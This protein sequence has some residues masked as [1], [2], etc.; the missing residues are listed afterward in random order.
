MDKP[1]LSSE[2][3]SLA[4]AIVKLGGVMEQIIHHMALQPGATNESI[5][6]VLNGLIGG[7]LEPIVQADPSRFVVCAGALNVATER[8]ADEIYLVPPA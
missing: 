7:V 1:N 8:I 2:T 4:E 5:E 6:K 3:E